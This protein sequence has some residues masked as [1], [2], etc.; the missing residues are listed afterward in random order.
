MEE[1]DQPD[2]MSWMGKPPERSSQEASPERVEQTNESDESPVE[3]SPPPSS[4]DSEVEE[5]T[6]DGT[7]AVKSAP[8]QSMAEIEDEDDS[9]DSVIELVPQ[10]AQRFYIDVPKL[11]DQ[12]KSQYDRLPGHDIVQR[13][14]SEYRGDRYLVK[15]ESGEK[16]LVS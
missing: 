4:S 11:A 16:E 5:I 1:A 9:T 12:D 7:P 13:I 6:F 15:L 8:H 2:L 14:L 3:P 10:F